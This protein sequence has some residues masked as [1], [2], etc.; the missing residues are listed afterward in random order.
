M[1]AL[2]SSTKQDQ[3][4]ISY[5][6]KDL[7]PP[8]YRKAYSD[9]TAW[10]MA[11]FSELA[12]LRFNPV[13]E[14]QHIKKR[15]IENIEKMAGKDQASKLIEALKYLAAYDENVE[16][17]KLEKE[18]KSLGFELADTFDKKG[19]QAILISGEEFITLAFRGTE[20]TSVKDIKTDADA[21]T[22]QD[23]DVG[24][25]IHSG[26]YEAFEHIQEQVEKSIA[27]DEFKKKPLFITGHSL[28][29]ALATIAAMKLKHEAGISACYT[30]GSP[31]VADEIWISKIKTPLYRV[32]NAADFVTM[33]PPGKDI[34]STFA[35]LCQLLP[36]AGDSLSAWLISNFDGYI[37]G[38]NMRY[39]TNCPTGQFDQVRLL[40][41]VSL[42]YRI[43][44]LIYKNLPW[45]NLLS[46]HKITT[47]RRKLAIVAKNRN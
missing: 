9:R 45:A 17:Q 15:L 39:L 14:N 10:L 25:S 31:R 18:L 23:P 41:S 22:R 35:W 19:T 32:V 36:V 24:A 26:F 8:L 37:H 33:L 30:F 12:Y 38:G 16:K 4:A 29:G 34:L 21:K 40:Y 1:D 6:T 20:A 11:C 46:D 5:L 44:A 13:F 3:E 27:Q 2:L 43:K 7:S 42:F 47:Y 28:G